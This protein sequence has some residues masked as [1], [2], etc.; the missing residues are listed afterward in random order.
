MLGRRKAGTP[1]AI[2]ASRRPGGTI[3]QGE[4]AA[5]PRA[6]KFFSTLKKRGVRF[7][8]RPAGCGKRRLIHYHNMI[9]RNVSLTLP[10][11]LVQ[12]LDRAA[13]SAQRSRSNLVAVLLAAALT[14]Q[15]PR[16][17]RPHQSP[18]RGIEGTTP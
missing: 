11:E 15:A 5:L 9:V 16:R 13:E 18:R 10:R 1:H 17:L 14:A 3:R 4:P 8:V 2:N 6:P 7:S 12:R